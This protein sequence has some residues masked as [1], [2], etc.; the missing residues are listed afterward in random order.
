HVDEAG[1]REHAPGDHRTA[2]GDLDA[3]VAVVDAGHV[4]HA[5]RHDLPA[6]AADLGPTDGGEVRWGEPLVT[7][8][9]VHVGGG[10]VARLTG[11]DHD[12]RPAL[13]AELEGG[14][15]TGGGATDHRHVAVSFQGGGC[16]FAHGGDDT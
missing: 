10:G 1:G 14:G 11:V 8:V 6:V 3:E 16:V 13:A 9:A 2:A 4:D 7:E 12:D 5:T 15:Q